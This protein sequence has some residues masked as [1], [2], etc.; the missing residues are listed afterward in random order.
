MASKL[1]E[2][3]ERKLDSQAKK[4]RKVFLAEVTKGVDN[5]EDDLSRK[6]R[7]ENTVKLIR[8]YLH[9]IKRDMQEVRRSV[10]IKERQKKCLLLL[11]RIELCIENLTNSAPAM[12]S[13]YA[14]QGKAYSILGF[15]DRAVKAYEES[16]KMFH[17]GSNGDSTLFHYEEIKRACE[18]IL[19]IMPS[20]LGARKKLL[21][22]SVLKG[23]MTIPILNELPPEEFH[24]VF[25]YFALCQLM[26]Q[27]VVDEKAKDMALQFFIVLEGMVEVLQKGKVAMEVGRGGFYGAESLLKGSEAD[28]AVRAMAEALLLTLT[29]F[30]YQE[31]GA[32]SR[33][34]R[35]VFEEKVGV[36]VQRDADGDD[37]PDSFPLR[38]ELMWQ[39]SGHEGIKQTVHA[40]DISTRGMGL[41]T[42]A[43]PAEGETYEILLPFNQL[44]LPIRENMM[45]RLGLKTAG[46]GGG[47]YP[48]RF[49]ILLHVDRVLQRGGKKIYHL[50]TSFISEPWVE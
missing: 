1:Q 18:E 44:P 32:V 36:A 6:L 19:N 17:E 16:I 12:A 31:A 26:P 27:Q 11:P 21:E 50:E 42:L 25:D 29:R 46:F 14:N 49:K 45:G 37:A 5:I 30:S 20:H 34:F 3:L 10:S 4:E 33:S 23:L 28:Y 43:P 48:S 2:K 40:H 47:N 9:E 39:R 22:L 24:V 13:L 38:G 35:K 15:P 8:R 41:I 7:K